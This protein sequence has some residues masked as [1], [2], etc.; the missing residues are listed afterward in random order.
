MIPS[1]PAPPEG[2]S[3]HSDLQVTILEQKLAQL[4]VHIQST[5]AILNNDELYDE[6]R[7][8]L[9]KLELLITQLRELRQTVDEIEA[10]KERITLIAG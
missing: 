6:Y 7:L 2:Q 4:R 1:L 9:D 3:L 5:P 8:G 10:H